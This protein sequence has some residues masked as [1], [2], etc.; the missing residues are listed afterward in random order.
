[1][2]Y[3]PPYPGAGNMFRYRARNA[4]GWSSYSPTKYI[5]A[6]GK[7]GIPPAPE[8]DSA[9]SS[10][11]LLKIIHTNENNG[12]QIDYHELYRDNGS[13]SSSYTKITDYDGISTDFNLNTTSDTGLV[14]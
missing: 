14:E 5:E 12:G 2:L 10:K 4:V 13:P 8:L 9:T 11:I 7:P 1:L 3:T 6:I